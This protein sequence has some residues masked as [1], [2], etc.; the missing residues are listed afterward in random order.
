MQVVLL[1]HKVNPKQEAMNLEDL[2]TLSTK[3]CTLTEAS[4]G[5]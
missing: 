2:W 4:N 3:Q 1:E 5:W